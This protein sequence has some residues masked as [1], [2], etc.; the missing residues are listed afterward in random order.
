MSLSGMNT[1][2][3]S[4]ITVALGLTS[5]VSVSDLESLWC[6][7]GCVRVCKRVVDGGGVIGQLILHVWFCATLLCVG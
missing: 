7:R 2:V 1:I 3:G 6:V 5:D 4:C